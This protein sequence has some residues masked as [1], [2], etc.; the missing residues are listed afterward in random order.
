M[1]LDFRPV[2][3]QS[4]KE[5]GVPRGW[6]VSEHRGKVKLRVRQGSGGTAASWTKT[7]PIAWVV[8]CIGPV[9][10]TLA[11]LYQ[12]TQGDPPK[13]LAEA[14]LELHPEDDDEE[15]APGLPAV[16]TG[17]DWQAIAD[18]FYADRC[19]HGTKI[20][21]RTLNEEKRY[22]GAAITV[23][24]GK[25]P[26][27]TP[28]LLLDA[29]L[30][31][32]GWVIRPA[33]RKSAVDAICRFLAFG[34]DHCGLSS[35]WEIPARQKAKLAGS[36]KAS[37]SPPIAALSDLQL[38]QLIDSAQSDDWKNAL[39]VMATY[40]LRPIELS[41]LTVEFNEATKR[42]QLFCTYRKACGGKSEKLETEPR[43]LYAAPLKDAD[44]NLTSVD[45]TAAWEA[46]LLPMPPLKE[47][48]R[49]VA[50]YLARMPLWKQWKA[51]SEEQGRTLR[52][53]SFRNS[54]SVRCHERGQNTAAISDAMGHSE[55]THSSSYLVTTAEA[56]ARAFGEMGAADATD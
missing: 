55:R 31:L 5:A 21:Q 39:R 26:P 28:Y 8:G 1:A 10:D 33:A 43:F 11:S 44:G 3:K 6:S 16:I 35:D 34:M 56:T 50:Q 25:R 46:G 36:G 45:L 4:I 23:L 52:P 38:L 30:E 41:Y 20:S 29:A 9:T 18:R 42:K 47:K 2:L 53:Y 32:R 7:L 49:A 22:V 12:S 14:W 15:P 24:T 54:Y 27:S 37:D 48:G 13:S 40:G 19:K 51:E 17:I